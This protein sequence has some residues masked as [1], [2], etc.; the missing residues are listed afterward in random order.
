[1]K[2][3]VNRCFGGFGLSHEAIMRYAELSGIKLYVV[4]ENEERDYKKLPKYHYIKNDE[5]PRTFE[6]AYLTKPLNEDGTYPQD[7]YWSYYDIQRDDINLVKVIEEMGDAANGNCAELEVVKIPDGI[8]WV[9]DEY[10]G[11]ETVEEAHRSW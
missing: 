9:L 2:I 10:D 8:D 7:S 3:V 6:Y 11:S 1:M 5:E 4:N